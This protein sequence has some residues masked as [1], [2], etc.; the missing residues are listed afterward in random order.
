[1]TTS[2][3]FWVVVFAASG[4]VIVFV[5]LLMERF[6]EKDWHQNLS[7]FRRCKSISVCGEWIVM[8]GIL[9]EIGVGIFSAIDVWETEPSN[10]PIRDMSAL[11]SFRAGL[12]NQNEAMFMRVG[13]A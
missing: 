5:G 2:S 11:V 12:K 8:V 3:V 7:D 10:R 1:M 6:S 9:I 4:G 13:G